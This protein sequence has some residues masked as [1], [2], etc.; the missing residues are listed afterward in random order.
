MSHW[1]VWFLF[2]ALQDSLVILSAG[3]SEIERRT[4]KRKENG[5]CQEL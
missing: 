3:V 5:S 1:I 2:P 4:K